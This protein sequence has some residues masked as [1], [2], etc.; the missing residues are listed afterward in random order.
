MAIINDQG[1]VIARCPD[2][3]GGTSTFE[4]ALD[5][6]SRGHFTKVFPRTGLGT[7]EGELR[8]RFQLFRCAGCGRGGLGAIRLMPM[9]DT[10]PKEHLGAVAVLPRSQGKIEA[11]D[12]RSERH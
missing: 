3:N 2:C 4:Y 11:A 12:C 10:Y 6:R 7:R 1:N 9:A 8:V 5:G